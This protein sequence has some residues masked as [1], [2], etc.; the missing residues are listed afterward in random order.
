MDL[1]FESERPRTS[2]A[3]LVAFSMG[4]AYFVG[5]RRC[6]KTLIGAELRHMN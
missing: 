1:T 3:V 2:Q 4:M 6:P 5:E